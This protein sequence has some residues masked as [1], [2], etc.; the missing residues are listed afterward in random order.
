ML[1]TPY[2]N[3][4]ITSFINIFFTTSSVDAKQMSVHSS[5]S[6]VTI[7]SGFI[8]AELSS[9]TGRLGVGI[10]TITVMHCLAI[11]LRLDTFRSVEALTVATLFD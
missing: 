10:A 7:F 2:G 5:S 11:H 9:V 6:L 8:L 4:A 1:L 3:I